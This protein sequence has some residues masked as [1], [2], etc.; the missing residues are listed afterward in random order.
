MRIDYENKIVFLQNSKVASSSL[1]HAMNQSDHRFAIIGGAPALKHLNYRKF[2]KLAPILQLEDFTTVCVI[3]HPLGLLDSWFRYLGRDT[4]KNTAKY[5]GNMT[6]AE[7][8]ASRKPTAFDDRSFIY[9]RN[10]QCV[11]LV[12]RYEA[13]NDFEAWLQAMYGPTLTLGHYNVSPTRNDTRALDLQDHRDRFIDAIS[14]YEGL[15]VDPKTGATTPQPIRPKEARALFMG[16]KQ[17]Q[18]DV[19]ASG[20]S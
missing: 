17:E 13:L 1:E 7:Y 20:A 5:T 19:Q 12:F 8:V 9:G 16:H 15:E 6:L 3:R 14:W 18:P 2:Q 4:M 10:G 11:D